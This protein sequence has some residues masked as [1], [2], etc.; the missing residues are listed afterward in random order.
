MSTR[1]LMKLSYEK[2][3]K[4]HTAH[5]RA[6]VFWSFASKAFSFLPNAKKHCEIKASISEFNARVVETAI[7]F[8]NLEDKAHETH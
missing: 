5:T 7:T 6:C 4:R 8:K 2:L 3:E 1:E